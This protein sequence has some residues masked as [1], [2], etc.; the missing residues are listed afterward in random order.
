MHRQIDVTMKTY[1]CKKC[2][3]I[4]Q[5]NSN[6]ELEEHNKKHSQ[7]C[8]LNLT[9]SQGECLPNAFINLIKN[10]N[11]RFCYSYVKGRLPNQ[12]YIHAWNE[13]AGYIE[14]V[15]GKAVLRTVGLPNE[16]TEY[17]VVDTSNPTTPIIV[18]RD[19]YYSKKE[20]NP[21]EVITLN[22]EELIGNINNSLKVSEKAVNIWGW[23]VV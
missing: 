19:H 6:E 17:F 23:L 7:N 8:D 20:L 22:F 9:E 13:C 1:S 16:Q 18:K 15:N 14:E 10:P 11:W 5:F 2:G 12:K 21:E 3:Y 4:A